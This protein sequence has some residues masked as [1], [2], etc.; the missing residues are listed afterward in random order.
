MT[1]WTRDISGALTGPSDAKKAVRDV[2]TKASLKGIPQ[3][4]AWE[5]G[6][7]VEGANEE[8]VV[9]LRV[10]GLCGRVRRGIV[11]G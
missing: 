10:S 4:R 3:P 1:R 8:E 9:V 2:K 6:R 5:K 7:A 11:A